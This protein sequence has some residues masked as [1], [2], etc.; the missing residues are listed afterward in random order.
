MQPYA[1]LPFLPEADFC[2]RPH[3]ITLQPLNNQYPTETSS[4]F[5]HFKTERFHS[6]SSY[7]T[8]SQDVPETPR[9]DYSFSFLS[10]VTN[11]QAQ[12]RTEVR[13]KQ[14]D[15]EKHAA[16][17]LIAG[18]PVLIITELRSNELIIM[19]GGETFPGLSASSGLPQRHR[20]RILMTLRKT[21]VRFCF[22]IKYFEKQNI[23][24][25][26]AINLKV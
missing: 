15:P 25:S 4:A 1:C 17:G 20:S 6:T 19:M 18:G 23:F 5:V 7:H 8:D 26:F 10:V 22:S 21:Q 11:S 12:P 13:R 16:R 2:P 3:V 24:I 9:V 14:K